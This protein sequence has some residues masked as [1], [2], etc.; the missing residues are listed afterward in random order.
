MDSKK[1]TVKQKVKISKIVLDI[2]WIFLLVFPFIRVQFE[3]VTITDS[4]IVYNLEKQGDD[5]T[6]TCDKDVVSG[7]VT[8]KFYNQDTEVKTI[9]KEFDE[10]EGKSFTITIYDS[11]WPETATRYEYYECRVTTD[12]QE[13]VSMICYLLAFAL[14]IVMVFVWRIKV[15]EAEIAGKSVVVY[16]GYK[17]KYLSINGNRAEEVNVVNIKKPITLRAELEDLTIFAEIGKGN[18]VRIYS[19]IKKNEQAEDKPEKNEKIFET[20]GLSEEEK[21][22]KELFADAG[23]G[24]K[25]TDKEP[26]KTEKKT[27]PKTAKTEKKTEVTSTEEKPK[28]GRPRKIK[29]ETDASS[30]NEEK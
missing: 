10:N 15:Y 18:K 9:K 1:L 23:V 7:T 20:T 25:E 19:E 13:T 6:L 3:K 30:E 4:E 11:D 28:R 29:P 21:M 5:M 8:L 27:K 17:K 14:V 12:A 24:E 22:A 2:L 26:E 16:K